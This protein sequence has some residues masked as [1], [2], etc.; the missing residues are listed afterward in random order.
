MP[1]ALTPSQQHGANVSRERRDSSRPDAV[2]QPSFAP[3]RKDFIHRF[4]SCAGANHWSDGTVAV[5]L[6]FSLNSAAGAIVHE[7]P[8][9]DRWSYRRIVAEIETAYGPRS[10]HAE[11]MGIEKAG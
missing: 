5:Q 11:A 4:E 2:A 3:H 10:E 7:N 8:R 1:T 6:R 9:S